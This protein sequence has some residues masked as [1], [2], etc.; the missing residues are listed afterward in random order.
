[1][2]LTEESTEADRTGLAESL[3][4]WEGTSEVGFSESSLGFGE[5]VVLVGEGEVGVPLRDWERVVTRTSLNGLSFPMVAEANFPRVEG[6]GFWEGE[7]MVSRRSGLI[8][9]KTRES[10]RQKGA[11]EKGEAG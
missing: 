10:T 7:S 1:M 9:D 8:R 3:G 11:N 2:G 6:E 5:E 4:G